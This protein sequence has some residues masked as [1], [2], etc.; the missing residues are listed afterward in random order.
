MAN[1]WAVPDD[2]R[3]AVRKALPYEY[4]VDGA[5]FFTKRG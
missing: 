3:D 1:G 2:Q 4:G 5:G